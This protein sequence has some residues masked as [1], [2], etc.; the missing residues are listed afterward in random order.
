MGRVKGCS[1]HISVRVTPSTQG[2]LKSGVSPPLTW[3]WA[4]GC[5]SPTVLCCERDELGCSKESSA[6]SSKTHPRTLELGAAVGGHSPSESIHELQVPKEIRQQRTV[7]GSA[8][9]PGSAVPPIPEN[10]WK[11]MELTIVG[12][13]KDERR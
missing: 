8:G 6:G 11:Q 9:G 10:A 12:T 3:L 2:P 7:L 5:W 4:E 1:S 13:A